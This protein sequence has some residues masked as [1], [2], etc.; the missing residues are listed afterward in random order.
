MCSSGSGTETRPMLQCRA[1]LPRLPGP[2]PGAIL[3]QEL[4]VPTRA[5]VGTGIPRVAVA[6]HNA[7]TDPLIHSPIHGTLS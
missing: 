3:G 5:R 2:D 1:A 6:E 4:L 7:M